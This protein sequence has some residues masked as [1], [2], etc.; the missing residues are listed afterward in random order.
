MAAKGQ[1]PLRH[2]R[3]DRRT[4]RSPGLA[5]FQAKGLLDQEMVVLGTEF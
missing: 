5:E 4:G 3:G 1:H 2:L